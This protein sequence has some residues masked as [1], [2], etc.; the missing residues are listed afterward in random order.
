MGFLWVKLKKG[1]SPASVAPDA[2]LFMGNGLTTRK[3]AEPV[4]LCPRGKS[5]RRD[6]GVL[7][8]NIAPVREHS[9][10]PVELY[11]RIET[12]VGAEG[13]YLELFARESRPGWTS[14]GNEKLKKG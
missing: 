12:Y 14:W 2:D 3:N 9:R 13:P 4:L 10:K 1:R 11:E 8:T 6:A 5:L 7:E